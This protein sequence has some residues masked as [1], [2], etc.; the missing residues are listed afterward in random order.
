MRRPQFFALSLSLFL[1]AIC[2][3]SMQAPPPALAMDPVEAQLKD[4]AMRQFALGL[5]AEKVDLNQAME[6]FRKSLGIYKKIKEVHYK[7]GLT[8]AKL[9]MNEE[10]MN[11]FRTAMNIDNNYIQCRN[12]YA[13]FLQHNKNDTEGAMDQWKQIVRM[14]PKYPFPYYFMGLVLHKKGDLDGAIDMFE[15]FVRLKPDSPDGQLELGLCIFE[16]AQTDD[17]MTAEK[18]LIAA[19][20]LAPQNPMIHFHLGT[21]EATKGNLD[22]AETQ[23]RTALQCDNRLAA[24]HWELARLRYLRGDMN[25]CMAELAAAQKI[26]PTYT[27]E[28]KYPQLR[29]IDLKTYYAKCLEHKGKLAEAIDAYLELAQAR[30]SD[31]LYAAHIEELKKKIKLIQ[32]ERK[33]KPLT[34]DP[35]EIDALVAKGQDSMEDGR[36][37][38][39]KASFERALELHPMSLEAT[40]AL[41]N[42]QEAQ[43]DLNAAAAS[44]QKAITID[45][46][47]GGAFYNYGF[48]LEKMNLPTDA[49][50]MYKRFQEVEGKYP[51]DPAHVIKLQQDL[52][53]QQKIEENRRTRGY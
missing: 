7:A 51:Y 19:Q 20:N 40:M 6:Y 22:D 52:I 38:E 11:E 42:V 47:F 44:N 29:V 2:L 9:G 5:Q 41:C 34:Y 32:K 33:K 15:S 18:A 14:E 45:P 35:E 3:T 8:A 49:G 30:G 25:F 1:S 21:I 36:L 13:L 37:E 31:A 12:D 27:A 50:M 16:R 10:A 4:K 28:K 53:R 48:L 23:W 26:N 46:T 43:G 24:A 17:I 39:A